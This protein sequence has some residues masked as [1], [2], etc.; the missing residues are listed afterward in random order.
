MS[1]Q[2]TLLLVGQGVMLVALLVYGRWG[3]KNLGHSNIVRGAQARLAVD[4]VAMTIGF[5]FA[6][7]VFGYL[8]SRGAFGGP[9]H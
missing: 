6:A 8:I 2:S 4:F 7:Y 9:P 3:W 5:S 1:D